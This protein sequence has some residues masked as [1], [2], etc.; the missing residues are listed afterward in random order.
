MYFT[1]H[2]KCNSVYLELALLHDPEMYVLRK[3]W[4]GV[5]ARLLFRAKGAF[6]RCREQQTYHKSYDSTSSVDFVDM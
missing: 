4:H 6:Q 3:A 2:T 5:A 1:K